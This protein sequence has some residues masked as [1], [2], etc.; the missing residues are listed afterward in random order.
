MYTTVC[1]YVT[2]QRRIIISGKANRY[3][4]GQ[5]CC[6]KKTLQFFK[7]WR[8]Y[9]KGAASVHSAVGRSRSDEVQCVI[10]PGVVGALN[11]L[12]PLVG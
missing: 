3:T 9:M 10:L 6:I 5:H 12:T 11:A 8:A 1:V 7:C 4:D 2:K